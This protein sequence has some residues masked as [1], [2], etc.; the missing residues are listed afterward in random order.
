MTANS[1]IVPPAAVVVIGLGN[2]GLPMGLRLIKAGFTVTGFD[3]SETARQNFAAAGGRSADDV[4]ATG[5]CADAVVALL[6][7]RQNLREG[8][9]LPPGETKPSSLLVCIRS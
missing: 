8:V 6:P 2:M 9:E 5:G 4:A 7:Q 1:A 3:V